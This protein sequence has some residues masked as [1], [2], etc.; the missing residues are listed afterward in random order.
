MHHLGA[1]GGSEPQVRPLR[2][3]DG[4]LAP[5]EP[6]VREPHVRALRWLPWKQ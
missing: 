2:R 1:C 6:H 3:A 4:S 5:G